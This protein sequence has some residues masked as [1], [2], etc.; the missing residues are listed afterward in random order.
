MSLEVLITRIKNEEDLKKVV[1]LAREDRDI[2]LSYR[3]EDQK[4]QFITEQYDTHSDIFLAEQNQKPVGYAVINPEPNE[5]YKVEYIYTNPESRKS[6]VA[7]KLLIEAM[8][9][10]RTYSDQSEVYAVIGF[11]NRSS[12]KLFESLGFTMRKHGSHIRATKNFGDRKETT[13]PRDSLW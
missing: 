2:I 4:E 8:S 9:H 11:H 10:I 5:L 3:N 13:L 7:K 6:S 1:S 12:R